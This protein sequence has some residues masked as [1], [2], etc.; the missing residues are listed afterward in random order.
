MVADRVVMVVSSTS[1][2]L[3]LSFKHFLVAQKNS[4]VLK[5][6]S[7]QIFNRVIVGSLPLPTLSLLV[8]LHSCAR[9]GSLL[10]SSA[11]FSLFQSISHKVLLFHVLQ[12]AVKLKARLVPHVDVRIKQV[13]TL[14]DLALVDKR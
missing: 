13:L 9:P 12:K 6:L 8:H 10:H 3:L 14:N 7:L 2:A 1:L 4:L 5:Y 11:V